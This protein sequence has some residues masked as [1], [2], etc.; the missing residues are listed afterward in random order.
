MDLHTSPPSLT[1]ALE[2]RGY[3]LT[4]SRQAIVDLLE[5]KHEGFT[6]E[7]L[8]EELPLVSR[9]TVYRTIKVL[10]EAGAVCKLAAID[11]SIVYSVSRTGHHHHHYVCVN[12]GAV[13]EFSA[14]AVERMLRSIA[15][16]LPGQVVD[17]RIELYV[18]CDPC[19]AGEGA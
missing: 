18:A 1:A 9:A 6:A 10:L 16:E 15:A 19:P 13:E 12:C 14:A 5:Q 11:G 2:D 4:L 3:R 7:G 8:S 17:H